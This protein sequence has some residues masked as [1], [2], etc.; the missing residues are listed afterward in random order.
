MS[1]LKEFKT[2]IENNDFSKFMQLWEEYCTNDIADIEELLE[3]FRMVKKSEM[4]KRF[5]QYVE[6]LLAQWQT[7]QNEKDSYIILREM[8]DLETTNSPVLAELAISALKKKYE[9]DPLFNDR[10]KLVGLRAKENFQ[11]AISRYDLL[12]HLKKGNFV[13]HLGGWGTGEII[14]VSTVR[15]QIVIEFENIRGRKDLSFENA[16]KTLIPLEDSHFLTRRFSNPDL[17]EKEAMKDPV[18]I[19]RLLLKDL[20]PKNA[21]E[22][23]DELCELVIPEASWTKWWQNT[24]PKIKKDTMIESPETLKGVFRLRKAEVS[25]AQRLQNAIHDKTDFDEIILTTYNFVRDLPDM[26]KGKDVKSSLKERLENLLVQPS[27]KPV[28]I[29]Q[30]CILL[31]NYFDYQVPDR[32]V[33]KIV[34]SADNISELIQEIEISAFKKRVLVAVREGREDWVELF[35]SLLFTIPVSTLRDYILKELSREEMVQSLKSKLKELLN[36]PASYPEVFV[37]YFQKVINKEDVPFNDKEGQELF[38][39]AFFVLFHQLEGKPDYRDLVKKMYQI[40]SGK[41]YAVVRAV[42]EDASI[43]FVKEFLLLA[44]KCQTFSDHDMKILRS[45]AEVVHPS[46]APK[47]SKHKMDTHVIWTTEESYFKTQDKIRRIGTVDI[48]ENA[49]E[50]EAAR[51][52]G[53]LRE[54]SEYKFALEKRSR[55]QADL[56]MMSDQ[57]NHARIITVQ[58]IPTDEVG[59]GSVVELTDSQGK[60]VKYTILGPWDADVEKNI[61]SFQSKLAQAMLGYRVGEKFQ[62]REDEFTV[63]AI[64]SFLSSR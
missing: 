35:L 17:L 57:F 43:G 28:Q 6:M 44:S 64:R 2:Q 14:D 63:M 45:L 52:L 39:E 59:I 8:I 21:A 26:L 54:N 37:W 62:F 56:K 1:Y 27:L 11:G 33:Q 23:K 42:F 18:E 48:V 12:A 34:Q 10:L 60:K 30:L 19:I 24:R 20:G 49:R 40:L 53:D 9:K 61:L 55:L 7:I 46:L 3:F 58:D 36:S 25:H 38:F 31:E 22:I 5:G 29:L 41:R 32:S 50:I 16:F 4:A 51:A 15:E 47:K 13:F